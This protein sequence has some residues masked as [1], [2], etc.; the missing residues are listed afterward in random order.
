MNKD[1]IKALDEIYF[2][3]QQYNKT[4]SSSDWKNNCKKNYETIRAALERPSVSKYCKDAEQTAKQHE[5]LIEWRQKLESEIAPLLGFERDE[6]YGWVTGEA[7]LDDLLY[8]LIVRYKKFLERPQV[9]VDEQHMCDTNKFK[10]GDY[11][12]KKGDKGQ[13]HGVIC[14]TYSTDCTPIGYAVE[15]VFERNSVQIYPESALEP[16]E[17]PDT[18]AVKREDVPEGV[19]NLIAEI[20]LTLDYFVVEFPEDQFPQVWNDPISHYS[21]GISP[22]DLLKIKAALADKGVV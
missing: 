20:D 1:A 14:G 11:V 19:K 18:I 10:R 13:W 2:E 4:C 17:K 12:R 5:K 9:D 8:M 7:C 21:G 6:E 3:A 15:S 22:N 16:W